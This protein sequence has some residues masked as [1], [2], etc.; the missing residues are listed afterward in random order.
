[1]TEIPQKLAAIVICLL[2]SI[3]FIVMPTLAWQGVELE[4]LS[5]KI[6]Q[7]N[8][9]LNL[10]S[11][12]SQYRQAISNIEVKIRNGERYFFPNSDSVKLDIQREVEEIFANNGLNLTGFN[13]ESDLPGVVRRLRANVYFSGVN[14]QMIETFWDLGAFPKIINQIGWNQ[15]MRSHGESEL[16]TTTGNV[17]LEFYAISLPAAVDSENRSSDTQ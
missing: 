6:L 4:V 1:M 5:T 11:A 12:Q 17:I 2:L 15:Q 16:G 13:W 10:V 14:D 8:K 7:L 3:K 9:A